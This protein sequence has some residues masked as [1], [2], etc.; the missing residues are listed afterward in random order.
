MK[1]T[2]SCFLFFI[3][4]VA[5]LLSFCIKGQSQVVINEFSTAN[6]SDWVISGELEDWVEMYNPSAATVDISG[7]YLS[8]NPNNPQKWAFPNGSTI[9]AN[10]YMIVLL[11]GTGDYD[12]NYLGYRNTSFKVT[13]TAGESLLFSNSSGTILEQYNLGT[14]GA[15]Q[16]NHSYARTTDG[17]AEWTIHTTT[18]HN[19]PNSGPTYSSYT[20][21]PIFDLPAGY[22]NNAINLSL[23]AEPGATIYYTTN[24]SDPSST[25]TL[26]TGP[27]SLSTTTTLRAISYSGDAN[28][29]RS[30][31]ETNTYFF[32]QDQHGIITVNIAGPTLS[33]GQ[34]WG[35][36]ACHIEFFAPSGVFITE[37]GGDS[38]EHGNDSNAYGQ[39]GFDYVTR[40]AMGYDHEIMEP[41]I[42]TTNR[43]SYE[44]L[45]FKAAANDNYPFAGGAH[46]RD[47][48]TC[49][50]SLIGGLNLDVRKTES[51]IVYINGAYWGVYEFREK[52][53]DTDYCNYYYNQPQGFIDFIKTWGSTWA[54][55]GSIADWNSLRNFITSNDMSVDANYDYVLTQY[56]HMSLIDYFILNGY[57]VC[58][59]WLNWNTAWWRGRHPNGSAKRWQYALWDNDAILGHYVNYTGI[60]NTSATS[61][62]CQVED[63]G[64]VGGQGHIPVLNALFQND[65]FRADYIQRYASLSN[66]IFSC[67][68]MT[69]VLDSMVAV[70]APEMTRQCQRW[71]GSYN[72]WEANVQQARNFIL[73]RCNDQIIGG[74]EG[75]YDVTAFSVT[76]QIEGEGTFDFETLHFDNSNLP[77]TG[78][79]FADLPI[80][81]HAFVEGGGELCGSFVGWE[82]V[83]GSGTVADPSNPITTLTIQ[84][85][86]TIKAIFQEPNS[87]PVFLT[88]D[89][90]EPNAGIITVNGVEQNSYPNSSSITP[91]AP[92]TVTVSA[93]EWFIF[94]NWESSN[95]TLLS[96]AN[97]STSITLSTC[98]S[99]TL[100]AIFTAIPHFT[101]TLKVEIPGTG[102]IV[103]GTDTIQNTGIYTLEGSLN[104]TFTAIPNNEWVV[105]SHWLTEGGNIIAG[106]TDPTIILQL[107][108]NGTI[109]AVFTTIPH[110]NITVISDPP[111]IAGTV[112]FEENHLTGNTYTTDSEISVV[113]EGN[114]PLRFNAEAN[115]FWHFIGWSA[116]FHHPSPTN[117]SN[118]VNFKFTKNDTIVAHFIKEDF[119]VFIPNSFT[120]N[121]D[122]NNDVFKIEGSAIDTEQFRLVIFNRWGDIIF[123]SRDIDT[124]WVGDMQNGAYY[125]APEGIYTY[126]LK[127]KSVHETNAREM[128]GTIS[129]IR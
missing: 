51:C 40:D 73:A 9:P 81:L 116:N 91:G 86:V 94:N 85:D 101:L 113:L 49:Q 121:N 42:H 128:T 66:T 4:V 20:T 84:G 98:M 10:G 18:T 64:N 21:K 53:D 118:P 14:L 24:G 80:D 87:E 92:N 58:S 62:P 83:S 103:F 39:R 108:A 8:D 28:I 117:K 41:L 79:Y 110:H 36:E 16:A 2:T 29:Y 119:Q 31:I 44:R 112:V 56:N 129:L 78:V 125:Y 25:S 96:P 111:Y 54:E 89:L 11:S 127:I 105:F 46:V 71:G 115:D 60:P 88:T 12:P 6:Y 70:I 124:V 109:T 47:P 50:L 122:G 102:R 100:T 82:I 97:N 107:I 126:T 77:F 59:D 69:D 123:E 17:G 27:I 55:Y 52:V 93:N 61:S 99:D 90:S 57:L 38:N 65:N 7:Y 43:P 45:I 19:A 13:Q 48:Y 15:L 74:I 1:Q 63:M 3:T 106:D 114:K 67:E 104:Y 5:L 26:Y 76:I 120:P 75:C 32:G 30:L 68:K 37:A 22:Y 35:D 33:D 23:T 34:W 72:A 95:G